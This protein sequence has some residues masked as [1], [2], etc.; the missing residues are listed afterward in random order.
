MLLIKTKE[1]YNEFLPTLRKKIYDGF[2]ACPECGYPVKTEKVYSNDKSNVIKLFMILEW[3]MIVILYF[4][5]GLISGDIV[6]A[7]CSFIP[8]CWCIPMTIIA[9]RKI[10][11]REKFSTGFKVCITI[12]VSTV[13]GIL[14]LCN[15]EL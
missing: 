9:F 12:F 7:F 11:V 3:S 10:G 8:I 4:I 13:A 15:D 1:N 2:T 14:L 6:Y 5:S